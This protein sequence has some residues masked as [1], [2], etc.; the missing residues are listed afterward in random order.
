M[1]TGTIAGQSKRRTG[2]LSRAAAILSL[3]LLPWLA[4]PLLQAALYVIDVEGHVF[5][6][7]IVSDS[8]DPLLQGVRMQDRSPAGQTTSE[9]I[10]TTLDAVLDASPAIALRQG[11]LV[12]AWARTEGGDSE[13]A[14]ALRDT[15]AG[16]RPH[17]LLTSN[18][19]NDEQPRILVDPQGLGQILWWGNSLGGP[20][21]LQAF[22]L[23][24]G[25][26]AGPRHRPLDPPGS[27]S[28]KKTKTSPT[29]DSAGGLDDPGIPT[30]GTRASALPCGSNPA[31]LPDHG[32]FFSCGRPAAYQLS[33]C[34]LIVGV[35]LDSGSWTQTSADLST[36]DLSTTSAREIMQSLADAYCQN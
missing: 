1:E 12:V 5:S 14:L 10:P 9:I 20:I 17:V 33:D 22:N 21:Y 31:A 27:I 25:A 36:V 3:A 35:Q 18:T 29:Y 8:V 13:L 16:W 23:D 30:T 34:R 28:G 26:T 4:G 11:G 24:T 15:G 6:V 19:L 7:D 2:R 32:L